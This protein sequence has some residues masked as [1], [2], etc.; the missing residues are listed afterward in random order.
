MPKRSLPG[1]LGDVE[2]DGELPRRDLGLVFDELD[3]QMACQAYLWAL[4]LVS[5]AQWRTPALRRLRRDELRP[6]A[7]RQLPG[8]PRADHRQRD[9]PV[10]PELLRPRR[11]RAAGHRA[12]GGPTAGG[13]SDF[14][15]REIGVLGEM[16]PDQ[17]KGGKHLVLPPGED[18]PRRRRLLRAALDRHEHH[19]RVPHA[20]PGPRAL[21]GARRRREDLPLRAARRPAADA[22]HL[23]RG[24]PWTG[25]QPR[26]LAYWERLHD[27]YQSRGRRRARPLL[28]GHAAAARHR[29]G[30]AVRARRP[31]ARHPRA[32]RPPPAS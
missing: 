2:L 24:S 1:R 4:P 15:Q 22:R 3:Y 19:V 32:T 11:D 6:R 10:H 29:E 14:W 16:G 5:Y 30:Q 8:P 28:P 7:L 18:A 23:A 20:G 26:G 31:A 27:I 17:G 9:D 13:V 25:D 12:A 21:A